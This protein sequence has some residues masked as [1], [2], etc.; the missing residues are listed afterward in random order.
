MK[1][2]YKEKKADKQQ[3]SESIRMGELHDVIEAS[4]IDPSEVE[5]WFRKQRIEMRK[6]SRSLTY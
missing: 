4:K 2:Q 1:I 3:Q 6:F 5:K